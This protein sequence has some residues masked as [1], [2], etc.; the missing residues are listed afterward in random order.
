MRGGRGV[1]MGER[2]NQKKNEGKPVEIGAKREAG[3]RESD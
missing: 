1:G 3:G 2:V